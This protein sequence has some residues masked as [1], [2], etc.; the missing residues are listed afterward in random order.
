[1][2][3]NIKIL[4]FVIII[5]TACK[6]DK[7]LT[8]DDLYPENP[9]STAS[10][11]AIQ[12][13]YKA[14]PYYQ[15]YIYR[16]DPVTNLWT[17]R[18]LSHFPTV[19]SSDPTSLGFTNPY[20]TNSGI[21]LFDMVKLYTDKIGSNNI[22]TAAINAEKVL[23]FFPDYEGA[24]TGIIKVIDQDIVITKS[25]S[26]T[27][28]PGIPNFKIGISGK[29]TYDERTKIFN[30]EVVFNETAIGGPAA[31]TRKYTMSVDPQTLN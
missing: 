1:M 28:E 20:V 12:A 8:K 15:L 10:S 6:K 18:I 17:N 29:G 3:L 14:D 7:P 24:K 2:K 31:V 19:P 4:L 5:M 23:K 13:F 25:T 27:F 26:A 16:F 21:A 30:L 9:S 11:S 22:K